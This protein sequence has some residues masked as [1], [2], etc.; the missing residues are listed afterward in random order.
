[1]QNNTAK[2]KLKAGETIFGCFT[3]YPNPSL[4]EV[5]G[6]QGW[7]FI[8]F[9]GE[10]GVLQPDTCEN[11]VRAA[12]LREVT[13]IVRVTTNQPHIIL[14]FMDT[15]AQ[16]LHIPW[17]NSGPEAEQAVQSVKYGPRGIRGLA[18]SRAADYGQRLPFGEYVKQANEQ[19]LIV[20]HI[21]TS[22]AVDNLAD[23]IAVE[24][25]DVVF[26][27][28]TDLSHSLGVP[29]QPQ[30][31]T[32]QAAIDRIVETV[33]GSD[34]ALGIMVGNAEA[35]QQWKARGARYIAIGL[36]SVLKPAAVNYLNAVRS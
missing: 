13:P 10:H 7:D 35:A 4:V 24:G 2:A 25:V 21:E 6:Y 1:L 36:E 11:M 17:V 18:G 12:E 23:I 20:L 19:T 30:H 29:G 15:G 27:G 8:V 28:P 9:D 26:I 32:T 5:M 33:A 31:P 14:R 16:G 22:T 34:V 3:R